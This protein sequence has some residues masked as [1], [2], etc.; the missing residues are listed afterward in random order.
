MGRIKRLAAVVLALL[1]VAGCKNRAAFAGGTLSPRQ[2]E[3][4]ERLIGVLCTAADP[5][6]R[7]GQFAGRPDAQTAG[8]AV[9]AYVALHADIGTATSGGVALTAR[10]TEAIP[11]YRASRTSRSSV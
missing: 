4:A 10:E 7:N 3:Q 6:M 1:S 8:Q 11:F 9:C 2:T 5:V